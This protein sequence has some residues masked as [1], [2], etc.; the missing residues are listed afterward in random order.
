MDF[1]SFVEGPLLWFAFLLF[2]AGI[3]SRLTFFSLAVVRSSKEKQFKLG[4]QAATFGRLFLPFHRAAL[5]KPLY[6]ILRYIFHI[7]LIVVPIW[8]S[9]HISLWLE[10]RFEWE[11]SA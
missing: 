4:Y 8:L 6:S 3:V 7:C 9:G 11:W 1:Y 2:I 5:H 10:S